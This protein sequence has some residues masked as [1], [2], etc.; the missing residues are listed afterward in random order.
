LSEF[1]V[2]MIIQ[3][4]LPHIGGA[5]QQ[6]AALAPLLEAEGCEVHILT[7]RFPGLAQ[8]EVIK[9]IPVH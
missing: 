4:Y 7:R 2:V 9:G 8:F 5:E 6:L 3:A 1:R